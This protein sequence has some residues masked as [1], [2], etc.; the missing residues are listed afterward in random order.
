MNTIARVIPDTPRAGLLLAVVA[1]LLAPGM[2]VFAKLL[3]QSLSPGMIVIA[4]A[5]WQTTH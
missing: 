4:S 1:F 2:D 3:T 5:A